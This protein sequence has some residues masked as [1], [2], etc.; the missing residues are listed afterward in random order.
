VQKSGITMVAPHDASM[1]SPL[2]CPLLCRAPVAAN[3]GVRDGHRIARCCGCA[4][5]FAVD[6]PSEEELD[7]HYRRYSYD[8]YGLSSVSAV[9][10]ARLDQVLAPLDRYR[11]LDRL[12]DVGFGAGAVLQAARRRGWGV[13]GVERSALAVEQAHANGFADTWAGDFLQL[14]L[15]PASFDVVVM[16]ELIEHLPHPLP[17]LARAREL[18][19]PGGALYLTTPN[20]AGLSGRVLT[21]GWSVVCPPEHLNLFSPASLTEALERSGFARIRVR[22]EALNPYELVAGI[23]GR[24]RGGAAAAETVAA[25]AAGHQSIAVNERLSAT[26]RGRFA[27][28]A[29]NAV[30]R[31]SRLGDAL[32]VTAERSGGTA[33]QGHA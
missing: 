32:K 15:E 25:V 7:R 13:F 1:H 9:V 20:G 6:L 11:R 23:R 29:V 22:T 28:S 10:M 26:R 19:R 8:T 27:K 3:V 17:F 12:L 33:R 16:T 14:D 24:L 30:L 18:V 5:L 31:L 4:H 21:T 2:N